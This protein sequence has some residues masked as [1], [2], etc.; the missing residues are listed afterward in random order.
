MHAYIP[1]GYAVPSPGL[2]IYIMR[3]H[4]A[5]FAGALPVGSNA[6]STSPVSPF[7]LIATAGDA[8]LIMSTPAVKKAE[9]YFAMA[10]G[11]AGTHPPVT[12]V[13]YKTVM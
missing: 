8:A 11:P 9:K 12:F 3:G 13:G 1:V 6:I 2:M 10:V 5:L 4:H 7:C